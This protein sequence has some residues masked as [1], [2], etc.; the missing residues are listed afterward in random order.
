M[1]SISSILTRAVD[2]IR[3]QI[4]WTATSTNNVPEARE[5]HTAV[6]TGS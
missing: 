1:I 5:N 3:T 4:R 6:W 2:T